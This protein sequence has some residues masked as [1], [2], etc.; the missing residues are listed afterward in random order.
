MNDFLQ[1]MPGFLTAVQNLHNILAPVVLVLM[2]AGLTIKVVQAQQQRCLSSI[3][4]FLVR[5]LAV[6]FLVGGLI[7]WGN[8]LQSGVTDLISQ[9]GL[10]QTNGNVYQAYRNAVAQRFGSDNAASNATLQG[11]NGNNGTSLNVA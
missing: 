3:L 9:L 1:L 5:M 10:T 6:S 11:V 8:M 4:P 7:T 2:F